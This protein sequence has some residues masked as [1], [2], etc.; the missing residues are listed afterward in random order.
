MY[1]LILGLCITGCNK[2]DPKEQLQHLDGYWEITKVEISKDSIREY[3]F[4]ELIDFFELEDGNGFRK[5][6]KPQLDGSYQITQDA[7]K[8]EARIEEDQ[9]YLYYS[10]LYDN[11]KEKVLLAEEKSLKLENERGIIYHYKR[12]TPFIEKQYETQ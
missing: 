9:L 12:F 5:K 1:L 8:V 6:V 7:E 11:W 4:N 3:G 2:Q 10:T